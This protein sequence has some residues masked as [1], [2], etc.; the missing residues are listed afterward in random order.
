MTKGISPTT[1]NTISYDRCNSSLN[2]IHMT[3][4]IS[5]LQVHCSQLD[6]I[7]LNQIQCSVSG[8]QYKDIL[9][10]RHVYILCPGELS[11]FK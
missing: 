5:H 7:G 2:T 9:L 8:P 10:T 4:T 6:I 11:Y 1:A 3:T